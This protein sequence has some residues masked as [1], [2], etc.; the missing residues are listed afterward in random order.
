MSAIRPD[1]AQRRSTST[2]PSSER[3]STATSSTFGYVVFSASRSSTRSRRCARFRTGISSETRGESVTDLE[4]SPDERARTGAG[5]R[6]GGDE[7]GRPRAGGGAAARRL[8]GPEG[9]QGGGPP[10]G[11][12]GGG[13][14]RA[15]E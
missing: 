13:T 9:A 10:R 7:G 14:P 8:R 4:S 6:D 11:G 5:G 12:G 1:R 3:S 2:L 15:G